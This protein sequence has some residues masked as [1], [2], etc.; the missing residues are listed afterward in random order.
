MRLPGATAADDSA[1]ASVRDA[2]Q[3]A[4][5]HVPSVPEQSA[6]RNRFLDF[7][8][9]HNLDGRVSSGMRKRGILWARL[10][11]PASVRP[12][13]VCHAL[14]GVNFTHVTDQDREDRALSLALTAAQSAHHHLVECG[15]EP[16]PRETRSWLHIGELERIDMFDAQQRDAGWS[17]LRR[18]RGT[19]VELLALDEEGSGHCSCGTCTGERVCCTTTFVQVCIWRRNANPL[20]VMDFWPEAQEWAQLVARSVPTQQV[21]TWGN[22]PLAARVFGPRVIDLQRKMSARIC[23]DLQLHP[24]HTVQLG[25]KAAYAWVA[26]RRGERIYAYSKPTDLHARAGCWQRRYKE[27][28]LTDDH[29]RYAAADAF[30]TGALFH[31]YLQLHNQGSASAAATTERGTG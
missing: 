9:K 21:A 28:L 6:T 18:L 30:A 26:H 24:P 20:V 8:R 17:L 19:E 12:G 16:P 31:E 7:C 15:L 27:T 10:A 23:A 3:R 22:D 13:E 25:L 2:L 14:W 1:L 11:W 5:M 29:K 4:S